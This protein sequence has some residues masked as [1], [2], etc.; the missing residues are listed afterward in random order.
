M[1]IRDYRCCQAEVPAEGLNLHPKGSKKLTETL[2]VMP[3][4]HF[5][6]RN[7]LLPKLSFEES[8][9]ESVDSS[10]AYPCVEAQRTDTLPPARAPREMARVPTLLDLRMLRDGLGS[11]SLYP[12]PSEAVFR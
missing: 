5:Y 10:Q 3:P 2:G 7:S 6:L 12:R 4:S 1:S 8:A 11:A 9:T